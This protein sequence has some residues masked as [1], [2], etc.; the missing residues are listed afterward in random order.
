MGASCAPERAM[1]C[2]WGD[3]WPAPLL[4][5]VSDYKMGSYGIVC[6]WSFGDAKFGWE[7]HMYVFGRM[8]T[9]V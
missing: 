8:H 6:C 2:R 9:G 7:L 5:I 4:P 1:A 3:I